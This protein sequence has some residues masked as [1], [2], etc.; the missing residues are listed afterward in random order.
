MAAAKWRNVAA[1]LAV[2]IL[3][4]SCAGKPASPPETSAAVSPSAS[5]EPAASPAAAAVGTAATAPETVLP[6]TSAEESASARSA[7]ADRAPERSFPRRAPLSFPLILASL[8]E[9]ELPRLTAAIAAPLPAPSAPLAA[10]TPVP[11]LPEPAP[12][13]ALAKTAEAPAPKADSA[14]KT[15]SKAKPAEKAAPKPATKETAKA[16]AKESPK[17]VPAEPPKASAIPLPLAPASGA[18]S[19]IVTAERQPDIA[20]SIAAEAGMRIEVPF[21]GTGWTYLGEKT[22]REGVLYETRRFEG[23][24]LVFVL[25]ASKPGDYVLR[26]QRQDALRGIAYDELVALAVSPKA[27]V[28]VP[29]TPAQGSAAAQTPGASAAPAAV[30]AAQGATAQSVGSAQPAASV[31]GAQQQG[32][33]T[34]AAQPVPAPDSPEGLVLEAKNAL[35]ADRAQTAIE[36]LDRLLARYPAGTDEAFYLYALALEQNGPLKDIKRAYSLY[37][38]VCADYPQ[39]AFW[40]AAAEHISYIERHYFEIR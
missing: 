38:K 15:A 24:G 21:D 16:A 20:R 6:A 1:A 19:S 3:F 10:A 9:P 2:A 40:D 29:A 13:K 22:G 12:A 26:F 17:P 8:H 25:L 39:S 18:E 4:A 35:R 32:S 5:S 7:A 31:A 14:A 34:A 27:A 36:A 11:A 28:S 23:S 37:K 33:G 30:A